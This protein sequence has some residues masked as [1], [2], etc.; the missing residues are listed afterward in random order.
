MSRQRTRDTAAELQLRRRLFAAGLRYRVHRRPLP[1]LRRTADILF[2]RARIAVFVDGCFWHGCTEHK[3]APKSNSAFWEQK[4]G[5]NRRRDED[6]RTRLE[7]AGWVYVRV[8][9]HEDPETAAIEITHLVRQRGK[10]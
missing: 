1:T 7:E 6:T 2:V 4:I 8:W 10:M 9:E 5:A 3:V